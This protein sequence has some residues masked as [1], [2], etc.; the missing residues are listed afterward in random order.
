MEQLIIITTINL[1]NHIITLTSCYAPE[2]DLL[3]HL[4]CFLA[5]SCLLSITT[6]HINT[7]SCFET[8]GHSFY[9]Y[10]IGAVTKFLGLVSHARLHE[11]G[12]S[13]FEKTNPLL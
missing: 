11:C 6:L 3:S 13:R 5:E 1:E 12:L 9:T 7:M 10:Y 2:R 8:V 4:R